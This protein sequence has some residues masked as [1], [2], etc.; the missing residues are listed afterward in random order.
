MTDRVLHWAAGKGVPFEIGA[1]ALRRD[2][3]ELAKVS[4]VTI[5]EGICRS[6][7]RAPP[8]M[9]GLSLQAPRQP[10]QKPF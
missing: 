5:F 3:G 8:V 10:Q 1:A 9:T 6:P 7:V 2:F 4:D